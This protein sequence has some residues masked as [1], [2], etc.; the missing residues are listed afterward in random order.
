[1]RELIVF[2]HA[3]SAWDTDAPSDFERP[4]N[5]RGRKDAPRMGAWLAEQE[6]RPDHVVCSPATRARQTAELL[7]AA[8][9]HDGDVSRDE[10]IYEASRRRL[11][12]VLADCPPDADR[13]L[14]IGHNPG[15]ADLVEFLGRDSV[16]EP[17]DGNLLPTATAVHFEI[18][19]LDRGGGTVRALMRPKWL[20]KSS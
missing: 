17:E 3:K 19:A 13:V 8:M 11:I 2:R 12:D 14:L 9:D 7:L 5:P 6:L 18:R 16:P 1:M 15:L 20:K 10:R 4:L